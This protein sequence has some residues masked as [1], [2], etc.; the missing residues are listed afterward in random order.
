M[1][2][3]TLLVFAALLALSA[4]TDVEPCGADKDM[5]EVGISDCDG[6]PCVLKKE[7]TKKVEIKFVPKKD[8]NQLKTR[9]YANIVGVDL[10][11]IGVDGTDACTKIYNEQGEKVQCPLKKGETYVYKNEFKVLKIYP[12]LTLLVKYW[13][14]EDGDQVVCFNLNSKIT[15]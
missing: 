14:E 15:S 6:A 4:A 9:V 13:L 3:E 12:T 10:P 2:R 5:G 1:L 11:F 8:V 7:T